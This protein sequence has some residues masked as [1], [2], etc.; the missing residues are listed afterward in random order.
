[1]AGDAATL[2]PLVQLTYL[3]LAKRLYSGPSGVVVV[4][5]DAFCAVGG[6][7]YTHCNPHP[8][9]TLPGCDCIC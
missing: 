9:P 2:A 4:G 7:F 8:D 6:P 5:C 3:N 1:V